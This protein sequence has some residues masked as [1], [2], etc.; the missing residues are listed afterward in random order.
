MAGPWEEYGGAG[1]TTKERQTEATIGSSEASAASSAASAARS[2]E[3]TPAD[4]RLREAQATALERKNEE[5]ARKQQAAATAAETKAAMSQ[6]DVNNVLQ[7]I[8]EARR[9]VSKWSTGWGSYLSGIPQ[10]DARALKGLLGP[11]GVISANVLLRTMEKMRAGSASGATGLGAMD[12]SENQTIKNSIANLDLGNDP[13]KVLQSLNDLDRS[14][15]RYAAITSGYNPDEREIALKFGLIPK[16]DVGK[17]AGGAPPAVGGTTAEENVSRPEHLRGLN[18]TVSKMLREGRSANDIRAYLDT[19]EP[20]LGAKVTNLDWWEREMKKPDTPL[21]ARPEDR[22]NVEEVRTQA[23]APEKAIGAIAQTPVGTALIGATDFAT[24]GAIPALTGNPEATRAAIKGA[25]LESPNAF[26]LGQVAG[27]LTGGA[28]LENLAARYGLKLGPA[29]ISALQSGA[30]GYGASE[31]KGI[32]ALIDAAAGGVSGFLGG[33]LGEGAGNVIGAA[34]RG[35]KD[36][37]AMGLRERGIPLTIGEIMGPR[38]ANIEAKL[39]KLPIVGPAISARLEEGTNAFN[40]AAFDE[41]LAGLG[42]KYRDYG[43]EVGTRGL[44]KARENVSQAFKDALEGV[45]IVQDDAFQNNVANAWGELAALPDVGPKIAKSLNDQ[46]G[47]LLQ[48]GRPLTG[49][50]V[51][52]ALRKLER[53]GRSYKN[54]EMFESSIAPRLRSVEDE[55][56]G[57]VERQ[58]PDVLPQYDAARSAWRKV[59]V[60]GDAVKRSTRGEAADARGVFTPEE[61]QAAGMANAE[62]FTGKGSSVTRD[63]PF[64]ELSES[65]IDVM[66]PRGRSGSPYM[67][68]LTTAGL[69]GGASYLTQPGQTTDPRT[70]ATTGSE[71]DPVLA[72]MLGLGAAGLAGAPYSRL[73]Q[74]AITKFLMRPQGPTEQV[75]AGLASKYAPRTFGNYVGTLTG[76]APSRGTPDIEAAPEV[77]FQPVTIEPRKDIP[78]AEPDVN[79]LGTMPAAAGAQ[80]DTETNELVLPDGTRIPLSALGGQ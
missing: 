17:D 37:V 58:A 78:A 59:S 51:Q 48:P 2:R 5:A 23:S 53:I 27:G 43:P 26:L 9:L 69:V 32:D 11:E 14:F 16:E 46:L 49:P 45:N 6:E 56:R 29:T 52:V 8:A 30:Y 80:F 60:L 34:A 54:N 21:R 18:V 67:L 22:V 79:G 1:K 76:T 64:Q 12:R 28:T 36:T 44:R 66:A 70:G 47:D 62:K 31:N 55:I 71:R 7:K 10:T 33:K 40:K 41:S 39:S 75:L 3:L 68:P 35:A 4:K 20:G 77:S 13:E 50:E 65:G 24:A 25:E 15:R 42:A 72:A 74:N 57:A 61:L 19:I 73:G 63:Y 38:A